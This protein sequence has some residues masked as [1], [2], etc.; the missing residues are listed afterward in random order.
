MKDIILFGRSIG[1]AIAFETSSIY[2]PSC[3]IL[4]SPFLSLKKVAQ[5]LYGR[6]ASCLLK[7]TLDNS[8]VA[9][10]IKCPLLVIHGLKDNIVPYH[11]SVAIL[12]QCKG[13]T[14]LKLV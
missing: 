14:R 1:G 6:G 2:H 11:H 5:D 10:T 8:A 13:F 12:G 9:Q 3:L 4:L 7:E